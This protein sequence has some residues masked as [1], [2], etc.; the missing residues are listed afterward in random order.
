M[1]LLKGSRW[2]RLRLE[3]G[4]PGAPLSRLSGPLTGEALQL[5]KALQRLVARVS[6]SHR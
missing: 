1:S 5:F 4:A 2:V 6:D 3:D